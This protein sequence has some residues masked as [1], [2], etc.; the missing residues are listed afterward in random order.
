MAWV[1]N[2]GG[3]FANFAYS[4][5]YSGKSPFSEYIGFQSKSLEFWKCQMPGQISG[6]IWWKQSWGQEAE[7]QE[8]INAG[9]LMPAVLRGLFC[10]K[11]DC[12]SIFNL[13][14]GRPDSDNSKKSL[15]KLQ[16]FQTSRNPRHT[17]EASWVTV[18]AKYQ[19]H[20]NN[21]HATQHLEVRKREAATARIGPFGPT[22]G[23]TTPC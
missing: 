11:L 18:I 4:G 15:S 2:Q 8:R 16:Q 22:S 19:I 13:K 9:M 12:L 10:F 5:K 23:K 21:L 1:E 20:T 7:F 14:G 3:C 17:A 6:T